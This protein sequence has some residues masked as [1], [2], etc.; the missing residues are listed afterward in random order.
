MEKE[1]ICKR[2]YKM[3]LA[4]QKRIVAAM[5]DP[6]NDG[7]TQAELCEII[8]IS[9]RT[10]Q[11]YLTDEL[12]EEIQALRLNVM[13]GALTDIDRAVF[14]KALAGDLAAAK[15]IYSRW[16]AA[17][18]EEQSKEK[19]EQTLEELN[20]EINQLKNQ[21]ESVEAA[22]KRCTSNETELSEK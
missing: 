20:D 2:G 8:G 12:W 15:L 22:A 9:K 7:K 19:G 13:S 4:I 11:R 17:R 5:T 16:D 14:V 18:K 6:M 21:I 10:L 3:D 1:R